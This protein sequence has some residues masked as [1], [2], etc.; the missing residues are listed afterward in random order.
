ML[1]VTGVPRRWR[2]GRCPIRSLPRARS[3]RSCTTGPGH[4]R[5]S[6]LARRRCAQPRRTP[7]AAADAAGRVDPG[8]LGRRARRL[9]EPTTGSPSND[10]RREADGSGRRSRASRRSD[11][12]EGAGAGRYAVGNADGDLFAVT[13]RCRHLCADLAKPP[14]PTSRGDPV[15]IRPPRRRPHATSS[16]SGVDTAIR[17]KNDP[18]NHRDRHD[19]RAASWAT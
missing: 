12:G 5:V 2:R 11:A 15:V 18:L 19:E 4:R 10:L 17:R 3:A 8:D 6:G 14:E 7:G 9:L 16:A 1:A 13:R